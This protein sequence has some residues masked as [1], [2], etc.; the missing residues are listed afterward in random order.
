MKD[1]TGKALKIGDTV[2]FI[3]PS[4]RDLGV[5]TVVK[6]NPTGV[7]VLNKNGRKIPRH[8]TAVCL[9]SSADSAILDTMQ[10]IADW[11]TEKQG[12]AK[13]DVRKFLTDAVNTF[14]ADNDIK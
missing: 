11:D 1:V 9:I 6:L 13:M 2:S 10:K 12:T 3:I 7:T 5:G 8:F 4:Y 14:I